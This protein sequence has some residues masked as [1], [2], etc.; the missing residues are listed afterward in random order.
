M[1]R[2]GNLT[3]PPAERRGAAMGFSRMSRIAAVVLVST[4]AG[5]S[6]GAATQSAF[7]PAPGVALTQSRTPANQKLHCPGWPAGS[8]LLADGDFSEA[9]DPAVTQ[10][11]RVGT[12]FAP[13]W[14]VR[15]RTIDFYGPGDAWKVP[16]NACVVDLDGSGSMGAGAIAH[17]PVE[18]K[19][20]RTY[21]LGF[22]FSGNKHCA[23][24]QHGPPIKTMLVEAA[25]LRTTLGQI[26]YWNTANGHDA[27]HGVFE[28]RTWTFTATNRR[29]EFYF[30]SLD[31]PVTTNCGP[32][33]AAVR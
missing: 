31:R 26:F 19:I 8:G 30:K 21:T 15:E 11:L 1:L 18:T 22:L 28:P 29:T 9:P 13:H 14:I 2:A 33:V 25:G 24:Y 27:E 3:V 10:G 16:S 20:G 12:E 5:C 23:H 6:G 17:S 4:L 7:A 32:M